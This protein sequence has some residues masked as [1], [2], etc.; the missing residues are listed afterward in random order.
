MSIIKKIIIC[1]IVGSA[2]LS[3]SKDNTIQFCEGV[4]NDGN[5]VRCGKK[6]TTG[7]ITGVINS[8]KPFDVEDLILKIIYLEKNSKTVDKTINLKVERD[9]NRA[10]A[11]LPFYNSGNYKV[12]L[13]REDDLLA[14]GSIEIIDTL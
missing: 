14:E 2:I 6:F 3:C 13:F 11:I 5:G 12:E 4:D 1:L 10:N 7:D 9:K 8:G